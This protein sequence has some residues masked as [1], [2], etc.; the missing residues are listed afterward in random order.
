MRLF[1]QFSNTLIQS[2]L[3]WKRLWN[4]LAT[5]LQLQHSMSK[6]LLTIDEQGNFTIFR[7]RKCHDFHYQLSKI[8]VFGSNGRKLF[9]SD[10]GGLEVGSKASWR[11]VST[12]AHVLCLYNK[13]TEAAQNTQMCWL[14]FWAQFY[15]LWKE[16][17]VEQEDEEH[18]VEKSRGR[19]NK[20]R[21]PYGMQQTYVSQC[22]CYCR[23]RIEER[24]S[25]GILRD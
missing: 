11:H 18:K 4:V 17:L 6:F 13:W 23:K 16:K 25:P 1:E 10:S 9:C 2:K 12:V 3:F 21:F 5:E 7:P 20:S 24:S 22:C 19:K 14:R 15:D 8:I